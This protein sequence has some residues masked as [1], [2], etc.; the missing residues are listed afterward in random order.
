MYAPPS[1]PA[2]HALADYVLEA[3]TCPLPRGDGDDPSPA[4]GAP[5]SPLPPAAALLSG[6]LG[7]ASDVIQ[8]T[9]AELLVRG[10]RRTGSS[11]GRVRATAASGLSR[12]LG[13]ASDTSWAACTE[14]LVVGR[15]G[16]V[17]HGNPAGRGNKDGHAGQS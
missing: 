14:L 1:L 8:A 6:R 17:Q 13:F 9:P 16:G 12:L 11:Q 3:S 2:I 7:F 10:A 15:G 4:P 5:P